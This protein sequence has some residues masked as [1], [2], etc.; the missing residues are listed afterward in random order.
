LERAAGDFF[1]NFKFFTATRKETD[2]MPLFLALGWNGDEIHVAVACQRGHRVVVEHAFAVSTKE[3]LAEGESSPQSISERAIGERIAQ[4]LKSRGINGAEAFVEVGRSRIEL[5]QLV[6]PPAPDEDLPDMVRFQAGREFNEFDE[7]WLL[8][9]I[10]IDASSIG[11]RAV[12][13]TAIAPATL[14]RI[15]NVCRSAGLK[16]RRL[17][18]G[19][20]ESAVLLPETSLKPV[21]HLQLQ[22][23]IYAN[24]AELTA[25]SRGNAV[26][27]RTMRFN[28]DAPSETA[29]LAE[30]RLTMAAVQNQL[31]GWAVRSIVLFGKDS[32]HVDWARNIN[33]Q[34]GIPTEAVDPFDAVEAAPSL[35]KNFPSHPG[36]YAALLGMLTAESRESSH[37]VDFLHPRHRPEPAS[38][39]RTWILAGAAVLTIVLVF[40]IH[41]RIERDQLIHEVEHLAAAAVDMEP[42][43]AHAKQVHL[44]TAEI[45][46]W[47]DAEVIWLDQLYDLNDFFPTAEEALLEEIRFDASQQGGAQIFL[48]G[49]ARDAE[50]IAQMEDRVRAGGGQIGASSGLEDDSAKG[51]RWKF[52][53]KLIFKKDAKP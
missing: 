33:A 47:A 51:Y 14:E 39:R 42:R 36:R 44:N 15:E 22:V 35:K 2:G 17:L 30:I 32:S 53:A 31:S 34:L 49:H 20:C 46:K 24:E 19:P 23:V 27:F 38:R 3:I 28:G 9:F 37:A 11:P 41:A 52:E 6:L 29:L 18:L 21:E 7:R 16:M 25:V 48:K 13:A 5:R 45:A 40:L 10:Q 50:I 43:L 8:D 4:E 1:S 12:L 26:F